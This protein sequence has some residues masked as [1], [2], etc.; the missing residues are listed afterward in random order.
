MGAYF[1]IAGVITVVGGFL[2]RG[3]QLY[4]V[5][6]PR[7]RRAVLLT[8]PLDDLLH[9][10]RGGQLGGGGRRDPGHAGHQDP[11][12]A[13]PG[14]EAPALHGVQRV[15][16]FDVALGREVVVGAAHFG[17]QAVG[18]GDAPCA[19]IQAITMMSR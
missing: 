8:V 12:R 4:W 6:G 9:A 17:D 10:T 13:L 1:V 3:T 2:D 19:T 14:P 11:V 7:Q 16:R 18:D 5:A 15:P